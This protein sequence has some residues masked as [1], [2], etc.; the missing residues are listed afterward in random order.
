MM[1]DFKVNICGVPHEVVF[2]DDSF[3]ACETHFGEI[4]YK[5]CKITLSTGM[6]PEM[7]KQTLIHEMV[8][9]FFTHLGYNNLAGDEVLVQS[10]AQAMAQSFE[11]KKEL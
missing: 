9:G 8:H 10:L 2:K 7:E 4:K 5:E 6:P 1:R 11:V 3:T